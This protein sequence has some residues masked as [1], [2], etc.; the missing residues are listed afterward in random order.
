VAQHFSRMRNADRT[1]GTVNQLGLQP[2]FQPRDR[3]R[4]GRLGDAN[5]FGGHDHA[6][7]FGENVENL[8]ILQID[9][10]I[11]GAVEMS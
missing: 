10:I 11:G 3:L 2:I 5:A 8:K 7:C 6:A 4:H 9:P 1:A